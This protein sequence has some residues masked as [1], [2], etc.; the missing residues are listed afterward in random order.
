MD[1]S[2][3]E[4]LEN[5]NEKLNDIYIYTLSK[6]ASVDMDNCLKLYFDMKDNS[7]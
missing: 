2:L 5:I 7:K 1:H 3:I 4:E 6:F